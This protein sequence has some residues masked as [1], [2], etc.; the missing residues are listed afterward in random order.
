M[1]PVVEQVSVWYAIPF[2]TYIALVVFAVI[3]H[4][5]TNGGNK[6]G[7]HCRCHCDVSMPTAQS[8]Y[9]QATIMEPMVL[10]Q[11]AKL[12]AEVTKGL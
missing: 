6:T 11:G 1:R 12:Y 7:M 5:A 10:L 8:L 9:G 2:L 4:G 3:R